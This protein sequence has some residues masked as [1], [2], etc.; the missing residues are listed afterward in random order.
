MISV[1]VEG[2]GGGGSG[3]SGGAGVGGEGLGRKPDAESVWLPCL[4]E[5]IN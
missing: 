4:C 5:N 1:L 2:G 3:V